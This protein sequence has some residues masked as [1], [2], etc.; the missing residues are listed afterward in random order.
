MIISIEARK[1]LSKGCTGYLAH[2]VG[3]K[4]DSALSLQ[5]TLVICEF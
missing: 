4:A 2:V 1:L 5:S 3:K